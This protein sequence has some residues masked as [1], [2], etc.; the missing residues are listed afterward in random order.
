MKNQRN[1][2]ITRK[3]ILE[4]AET[5]FL[6]K[7]FGATAISEIAGKAGV[8]K[9]LIHHYFN[10]KRALWGEVKNFRFR[11]FYEKQIRIL[12]TSDR[13]IEQMEG[14]LEA[15][16]TFLSENPQIVRILSWMFLESDHNESLELDQ[17]LIKAG[18]AKILDGQHNGL[19]RSD[20][21]SRY[22]MYMVVSSALSW[23]QQREHFI[24]DFGVE[25]LPE[26][27]DHAFFNAMKTIIFEGILNR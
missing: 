6:E 4:A 11:Q 5:L 21:D 2:E 20:I 9:S 12:K 22:I 26:N 17:Q 1:P 25:G 10:S 7:G 13:S 24:R 19:L 27:I 15:Y 18:N 8:T 3:A 14:S 16:F 23:F